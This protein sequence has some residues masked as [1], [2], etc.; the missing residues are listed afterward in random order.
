M[1]QHTAPT[2]YIYVPLHIELYADLIRRSGKSDVSGYIDHS[3]ESFLERTEGDPDIWS[4]EY[5]GKLVDEEDEK[6]REKFGDPGR[7][8]QWYPIFLQNGSKLRMSYKGKP[9]YAEIRHER[10]YDEESKESMSSPSQFAIHVA[11]HNRNA[12]RHLYIKF[13]GT[14][15]WKLADDV[16]QQVPPPK[17][18]SLSDF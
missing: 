1:K 9:Y 18:F 7:G 13:P 12:W 2:D 6:F 17:P 10:V 16:R 8:Y 11:G 15:S 5:I 4:A 3:V 14:G